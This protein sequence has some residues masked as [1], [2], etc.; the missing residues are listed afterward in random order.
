VGGAA[1]SDRD[2]SYVVVD[3]GASSR[4]VLRLLDLVKSRVEDRFHLE[5]DTDITIW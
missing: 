3:A 1:V 5:L 4:D 2:A